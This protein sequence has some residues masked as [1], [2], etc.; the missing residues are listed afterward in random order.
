MSYKFSN[1]TLSLKNDGTTTRHGV[2]AFN[3]V[4]YIAFRATDPAMANDFLP[5][6][7]KE[8]APVLGRVEKA[9][10]DVDLPPQARDIIV[11][12]LPSTCKFWSHPIIST[13]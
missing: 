12:E 5:P 4:L 2:D 9:F 10:I 11:S 7:V 13:D 3:F 6:M 1:R 8:L